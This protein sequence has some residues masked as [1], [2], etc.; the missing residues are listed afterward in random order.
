MIR[1]DP[2]EVA[3]RLEARPPEE[4]SSEDPRSQAEA[5]LQDTEDRLEERGVKS[6]PDWS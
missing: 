6:E 2:H 1:P 5:I 4:Q 3:S